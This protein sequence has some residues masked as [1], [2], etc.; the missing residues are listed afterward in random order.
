MIM[1]MVFVKRDHHHNIIYD[2]ICGSGFTVE[3]CGI[4]VVHAPSLNEAGRFYFA[5]Y[6]TN[7]FLSILLLF[8]ERNSWRLLKSKQIIF[9][10]FHFLHFF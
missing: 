1:I 3:K 2:Y 7:E 8:G 6:F 10:V 5:L 9:L 4:P